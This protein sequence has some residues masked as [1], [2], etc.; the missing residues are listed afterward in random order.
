MD[1]IFTK[2]KMTEE[3]KQLDVLNF[4]AIAKIFIPKRWVKKF[5]NCTKRK[6]KM[7]I[8]ELLRGAEM[9]QHGW[10][11]KGGELQERF[12]GTSSQKRYIK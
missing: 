5:W 4:R 3:T 2:T 7:D 6:Y 12:R 10:S 1:F 9:T 8:T 11:E